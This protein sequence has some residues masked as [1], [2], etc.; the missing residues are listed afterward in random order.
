[1]TCNRCGKEI[2]IGG[3]YCKYCGYDSLLVENSEKSSNK[4]QTDSVE[5]SVSLKEV[6]VR[7]NRIIFITAVVVV[8]LIIIAVIVS[9]VRSKKSDAEE[10]TS[11]VEQA[12]MPSKTEKTTNIQPEET[13]EPE[14]AKEIDESTSE[15]VCND[16]T[17]ENNQIFYD[18]LS[19]KQEDLDGN[20][21]WAVGSDDI[22]YAVL[23]MNGDNLNELLIRSFGYWIP[24]VMVV[25][26]GKVACAGVETAGSSGLSI[27]NTNNQYVGADNTHEGRNMYWISEIGDDGNA[28]VV[29]FFA[30][31]W[32]DWATS[33]TDE[34]YMKENPTQADYEA[35]NYDK[36]TAAEYEKLLSEYVSENTELTWKGLKDLDFLLDSDSA[37]DQT[38]SSANNPGAAIKACQT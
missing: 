18:Y 24:D 36:I 33:G 10:K 16:I 17:N 20:M 13:K 7:N 3:R 31:Y 2:P 4:G 6:K 35:E 22:E 15:E 32:G 25:K 14:P 21:F 19:G 9:V 5:K 11:M 27:I 1:M 29:L 8:A 34:F 28:Q 30:Q 26:D 37:T 38:D 12:S 23:D